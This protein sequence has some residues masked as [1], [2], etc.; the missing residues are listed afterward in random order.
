MAAKKP[1]PAPR[2][3]EGFRE[4]FLVHFTRKA[5]AAALRRLGL[6]V[7]DLYINAA[8]RWW[9]DHIEGALRAVLHAAIRDLR[10]L[11]DVLSDL[12]RGGDYSME[13]AALAGFAGRCGVELEGM[14]CRL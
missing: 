3:R 13:G 4:T 6:L 8:P 7:S 2:E 11:R 14:A 12:D 10:H 1:R 9:P 5:D